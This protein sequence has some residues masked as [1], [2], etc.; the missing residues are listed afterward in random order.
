MNYVVNDNAT[1]LVASYNTFQQQK[2]QQW[3]ILYGTIVLNEIVE[4]YKQSHKK[5]N[6][7]I[8]FMT[9]YIYYI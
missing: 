3:Q 2:K 4:R 6:T 9:T 7:K 5:Y 8:V 1:K